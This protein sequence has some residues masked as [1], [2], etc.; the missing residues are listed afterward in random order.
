MIAFAWVVSIAAAARTSFP[1][2]TDTG[3]EVGAW[4]WLRTA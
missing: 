1:A 4:S 3:Q 2:M